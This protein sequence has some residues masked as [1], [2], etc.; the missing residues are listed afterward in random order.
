MRVDL[1]DS[2]KMKKYPTRECH[3]LGE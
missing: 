2:S 1:G 3:L